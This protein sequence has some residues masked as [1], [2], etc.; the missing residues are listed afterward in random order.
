MD[1]SYHFSSSGKCYF[2]HHFLCSEDF[3][4]SVFM[5]ETVRMC[6]DV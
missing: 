2:V 4:L 5:F 6:V 1:V 3:I